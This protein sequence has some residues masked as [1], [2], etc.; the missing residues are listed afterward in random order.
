MVKGELRI[1][2]SGKSKKGKLTCIVLKDYG[3]KN[4]NKNCLQG[5]KCSDQLIAAFLFSL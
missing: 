1:R 4:E 3:V 2:W 5:P